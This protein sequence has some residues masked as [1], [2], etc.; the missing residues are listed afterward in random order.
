MIQYGALSYNQK[1]KY[2]YDISKGLLYLH[3]RG[4]LVIELKPESVLI[5]KG[6]AKISYY[7]LK[8]L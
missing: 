5:H 3:E 4:V 2:I 6:T 1:L 7:G 8:G